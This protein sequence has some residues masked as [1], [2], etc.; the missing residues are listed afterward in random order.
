MRAKENIE[1]ERPRRMPG[2]LTGRVVPAVLG[3]VLA[4]LGTTTA[5]P[6]G[7][8]GEPAPVV[9][10]SPMDQPIALLASTRAAIQRVADYECKL[11]KRERVG[12]RLL[13]EQSITVKARA[14]PFSI[15]L[16]FDSPQSVRG[17]QICYVA[18]K[19][20][21]MMRVHPVGLRGIVGFVSIDPRDPRAFEDNRHAITEAGLWHLVD[22]TARYWE[23][24]RSVNK[25]QVRV[26]DAEFNGRPCTWIETTHPDR[27]AA[28]YY[29][30]RCVI[31]LDKQTF[32]PVRMEAYD[33]P[34]PGGTPGGDQLECYSYLNFRTN[35][36]LTD[37]DFSY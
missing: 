1:R 17:Q 25:T 27:T 20:Q 18:G 9:N 37:R 2:K 32:L 6:R 26:A 4:A 8:R 16:R 12:G 10:P 14:R 11:I 36:G 31:C 24:E 30:Y 21:G 3:G 23:M 29:A 28:R 33:W 22:S 19:N 34:R 7:A 5:S 35:E 13:P 15:Y